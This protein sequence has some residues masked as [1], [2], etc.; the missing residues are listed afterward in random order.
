[1]SAVIKFNNRRLSDTF[2]M[3]LVQFARENFDYDVDLVSSNV[4]VVPAHRVILSI[5]SKYL[6]R[7]LSNSS[8]EKKLIG[9]QTTFDL[10]KK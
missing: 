7:L 4:K 2:N 5:Y 9:K 8:P 10:T 6:R 1:M 3:K